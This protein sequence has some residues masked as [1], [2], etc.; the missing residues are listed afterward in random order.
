MFRSL[1]TVFS[2]DDALDLA[3][4]REV[5][6]SYQSAHLRNSDER[7]AAKEHQELVR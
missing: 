3:E 5:H 6:E 7:R 4:I 2:L 1:Q